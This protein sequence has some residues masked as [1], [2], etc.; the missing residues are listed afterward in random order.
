MI[1]LPN[2]KE[3]MF[4]AGEKRKGL[5]VV[6]FD[7]DGMPACTNVAAKSNGRI[8]I[9]CGNMCIMFHV[10][11]DATYTCSA[12]GKFNLEELITQRR[13]PLPGISFPSRKEPIHDA[14]HAD[15]VNNATTTPTR[16][17]STHIFG[18]PNK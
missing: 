1:L 11:E 17:R 2:T 10:N 15:T 4:A 5:A 6:Y 13:A 9:V 8:C 7:R 12:C 18:T 16:N 14:R 3:P